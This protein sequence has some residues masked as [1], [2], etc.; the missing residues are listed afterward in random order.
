MIDCRTLTETISSK[1]RRRHPRK[2][3]VRRWFE[4]SVRRVDRS[5]MATERSIALGSVA[6]LMT[7]CCALWPRRCLFC[8]SPRRGVCEDGRLERRHGLDD[9]RVTNVAR[10]VQFGGVCMSGLEAAGRTAEI[11]GAR[12]LRLPLERAEV[13]DSSDV[14]SARPRRIVAERRALVRSAS[15]V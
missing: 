2:S 1:W 4:L 9:D 8:F 3:V 14:D 13:E 12:S 10:R 5:S 6:P 7:S 15:G 11:V